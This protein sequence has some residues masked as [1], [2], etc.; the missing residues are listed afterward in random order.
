MNNAG[1]KRNSLHKL[2]MLLAL[3]C[4][5]PLVN[6]DK[7]VILASIKPLAMIA[8][9]VAGDEFEVRTLLP[10]S[11]SPHDYALRFSDRSALLEADLVLWVGPG[12]ETPLAKLLKPGALKAQQVLQAG[13]LPQ[14]AW[15]QSSNKE[16]FNSEPSKKESSNK[17]PHQHNH[18]SHA[19]RD[20]HIWLNPDNAVQI[21]QAVLAH[22]VKI[23]PEKK[24]ELEANFSEFV[25]KVTNLT[26]ITRERTGPIKTTGF[27]V[28][29]DGFRHWVDYYQLR[30]LGAVRQS[31]GAGH[32]L[33]HR[34]ELIALQGQVSCI[35]SEPQLPLEWASQL[36]EPIKARIGVLDPM[37]QDIA[38]EKDSY[39]QLMMLMADNLVACLDP[40]GEDSS[41]GK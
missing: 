2:A 8:A 31:S 34:A 18:Y 16:S 36:A 14:L 35:F 12:M 3:W 6:A 30:Q 41:P 19:T 11:S 4:F 20:P 39:I 37:G 32:G 21:A 13:E 25:A 9:A 28:V 26:K 23:S 38:L 1:L 27:L 15:P 10:S 33:K 5:S 40:D 24:A 22:L 17:E 7:P 29:H